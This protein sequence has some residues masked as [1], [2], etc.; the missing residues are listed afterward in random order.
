MAKTGRPS[1]GKSSPSVFSLVRDIA[2]G[3]TPWRR[4]LALVLF[5][6]SLLRRVA[7]RSEEV[8]YSTT[9]QPG[10]RL[11]VDHLSETKG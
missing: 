8:V 2:I 5:G 4:R 3:G 11:V 7:A 10:Q 6:W 9:L 1:K